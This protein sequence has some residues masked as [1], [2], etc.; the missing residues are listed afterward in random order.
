MFAGKAGAYLSEAPFGVGSW[1]Y[2]QTLD[3]AEKACQGQ[4][5]VACYENE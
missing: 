4:T 5:L 1:P 2:P 3:L